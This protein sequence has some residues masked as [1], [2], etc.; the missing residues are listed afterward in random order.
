MAWHGVA[1]HGGAGTPDTRCAGERGGTGE[2]GWGA[3][4]H[5]G[6]CRAAPGGGQPHREPGVRP[7]SESLSLAVCRKEQ[8]EPLPE[9]KQKCSSK[10]GRAGSPLS[11]GGSDVV[12]TLVCSL[13]LSAMQLLLSILLPASRRRSLPVFHPVLLMAV[14]G[15]KLYTPATALFP[16]NYTTLAPHTPLEVPRQGTPQRLSPACASA[17]LAMLRVEP[18]QASTA[19]YEYVWYRERGSRKTQKKRM[20]LHK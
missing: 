19:G 10:K 6:L 9:E 16:K 5:A 15:R 3:L 4:A 13:P 7:P 11:Q 1:R 2:P 18:A 20:Q 14:T 12:V 8:K 17:P